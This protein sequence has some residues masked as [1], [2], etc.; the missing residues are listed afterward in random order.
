MFRR[1]IS[2]GSP[3]LP[4]KPDDRRLR[5]IRYFVPTGHFQPALAPRAGPAG[6]ELAEIVEIACIFQLGPPVA[7]ASSLFGAAAPNGAT[8]PHCVE[9][10]TRPLP[11]YTGSATFYELSI[12][13]SC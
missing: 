8:R 10:S 1:F 13:H 2:H 12:E 6:L 11:P 3:A 7:T 9:F 4:R 5:S